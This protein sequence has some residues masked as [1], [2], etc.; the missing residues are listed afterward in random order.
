MPQ[1]SSAVH[2][3]LEPYQA[4]RAR[5]PKSSQQILAQYDEA[6]VIVYQ[7]YRPSVEFA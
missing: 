7:A 2:L 1:A 6:P 5:W 3:A 4:Q